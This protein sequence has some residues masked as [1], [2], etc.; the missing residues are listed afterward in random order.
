MGKIYFEENDDPVDIRYDNVFKAVFTKNTSASRGA[1]SRLVSALIGQEVSVTSILSNEPP[2]ES[3]NERQ[4]RFDINCRTKNGELLDVEMSFNPD[5]F[6]PVR[7]EYHAG[8]LFTGQEIRGTERTYDD[9]KRA[10]QI[11]IL[12]KEQF[13][14]D[15]IFL[16]KFE[17]HDSANN[18]PLNG[19]SRIITLELSKL[20]EVVKKPV[21]EMSVQEYWGVYFRYL[22]DKG[23]RSKINEILE[24]EEGIAMASKVLQEISKDENEKA[25]LLS[26]LK[27]ELDHQSKLVHAKREGM[28]KGLE[29]GVEKGMKRGMKKGRLETARNA[30]TEGLPI[31]VIQK[32]TGL[33][34]DTIK[35]L[36]S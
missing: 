23:K 12:A 21:K 24:H 7:L 32:I 10:Y 30:L 13:F 18:M 35:R 29:K 6:E 31:N 1:L 8:K 2:V 14:S 5:P 34:K 26:E 17:Y 19:R 9:L 36:S 3:I 33:D 20:G 11:A 16:H 4:I 25:R 22:T 27:Y 15:E 28:K